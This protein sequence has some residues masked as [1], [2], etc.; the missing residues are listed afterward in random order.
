MNQDAVNIMSQY[1]V[2]PEMTGVFRLKPSQLATWTID[3]VD[4]VRTHDYVVTCPL[5][6]AW[7]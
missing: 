7:P 5:L 2:I 6:A 3:R 4:A 1:I